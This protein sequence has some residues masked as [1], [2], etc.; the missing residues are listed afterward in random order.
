[1]PFWKFTKPLRSF[2]PCIPNLLA[3]KLSTS[4]FLYSLSCLTCL[5]S[6]TAHLSPSLQSVPAVCTYYIAL[7]VYLF[8]NFAVAGVLWLHRRLSSRFYLAQ[9]RKGT[10]RWRC[11]CD[12]QGIRCGSPPIEASL[13]FPPNLRAG[14]Q[15]RM[16]QLVRL[17]GR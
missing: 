12:R 2:I 3:L 7:S 8:T 10:A 14:R 4:A 5:F 1:M 13:L 16:K 17:L 15:Y 9:A 6:I 11:L